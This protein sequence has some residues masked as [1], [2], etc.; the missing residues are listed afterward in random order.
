VPSKLDLLLKEI[1]GRSLCQI[2]SLGWGHLTIARGPYFS[3]ALKLGLY[4]HWF[5]RTA[6][7]WV[8]YLFSHTKKNKQ[9]FLVDFGG[10]FTKHKR[11]PGIF[12]RK[13]PT[14]K[15]ECPQPILHKSYTRFVKISFHLVSRFEECLYN[16]DGVLLATVSSLTLFFFGWTLW[17]IF[18]FNSFFV[19]ELFVEH[20]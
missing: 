3:N 14:P 8:P 9:A 18:N 11:L 13:T 17:N 4:T 20:F 5:T 12:E 6:W 1:F 2:T 19:W 10:M 7:A 16:N 15:T